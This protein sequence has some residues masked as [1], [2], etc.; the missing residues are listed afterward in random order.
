MVADRLVLD[1]EEVLL[2]PPWP[3]AVA[4]GLEVLL[5]PSGDPGFLER[6]ADEGA[7]ALGVAQTR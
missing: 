2:G 7:A 4:E 6:M 1:A 5:G 3:A